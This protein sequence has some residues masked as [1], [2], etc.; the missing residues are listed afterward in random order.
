MDI[1]KFGKLIL[2]LGVII[3]AFGAFKYFTNLDEKFDSSK[4]PRSIFG[5]RNDLGEALRVQEANMRH[6]YEREQATPYFIGGAIVGFIGFAL[7]Y[8]AK[9]KQVVPTQD[10]STATTKT[11]EISSMTKGKLIFG[12]VLLVIGVIALIARDPIV[13]EIA[14]HKRGSD[15]MLAYNAFTYGGYGVGALGLVLCFLGLQKKN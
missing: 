9:R 14:K 10:N 11:E 12:I 8:S 1:Q 13:T 4:S 3:A 2:V 5:G 6:K 7:S 15:L